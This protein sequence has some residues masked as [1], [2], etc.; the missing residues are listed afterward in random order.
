MRNNT[1]PGYEALRERVARPLDLLII[2]AALA[3]I[4]VVIA[5]ERGDPQEWVAIA[6]W[7]IWSIFTIDFVLRGVMAANR[8]RYPID[9]IVGLIIVV[10]SFPLLPYML[11]SVRLVRIVRVLSL[12]RMIRVPAALMLG[13]RAMRRMVGIQS[14]IYVFVLT[15]LLAVLGAA[16]LVMVEPQTVNYSF[17]DGLWWA[18]V[19][20]STVGY[21]DIAPQTLP[22]RLLAV[23]LMLSGLGLLSTLAASISSY[24]IVEDVK[25]EELRDRLQRIEAILEEMRAEGRGRGTRE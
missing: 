6:D 13:L 14:M 10:C 20:V 2:P 22:G 23:I 19:T 4:P 16:L 17:M 7:A 12:V 21:G 1:R 18:L 24:F 8:A 9:N 25:L 5:Q 11:A 15:L 3:T